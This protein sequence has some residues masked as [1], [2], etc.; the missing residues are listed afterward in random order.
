MT[1]GTQTGSLSQ[2]TG[3]EWEVREG[4]MYTYGWFTLTFGRKQQN[5]VKQLSYLSIKNK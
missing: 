4:H 3:V 5:Y 1:Q 2:L